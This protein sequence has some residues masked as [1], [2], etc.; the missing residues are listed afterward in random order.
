MKS[1]C[2]SRVFSKW[3]SRANENER[4]A[5]MKT[6]IGATTRSNRSEYVS[7]VKKE[8]RKGYSI[9]MI[10]YQTNGI[11]SK[12]LWPSRDQMVRIVPGYDPVTGQVFSQNIN[13]NEYCTD[14]NL[15]DYL[16]DTFILST[17]VNGFGASRQ[18]FITDFAPGSPDEEK[19]GG[20]TPIHWFIRNMFYS[21]N[22]K[23]K[24]KPKYQPINEWNIWC[25]KNGT[26]SFDKA[27]LMFQAL[28]YKINGKEMQDENEQPL[29][30]EQGN[31]LPLFGIVAIDN[32]AS[33][34]LLMQALVEPTNPALPLDAIN[35]NKY[36]G[37]AEMNGNMLFLNSV[38]DP[39]SGKSMMRPSVQLPGKGWTATPLPLSEDNVKA[40]WRPWEQILHYMTA[41]E[42]LKLLAAEFGADT[43]NYL[44]G[45]DPKFADL[46]MPDE[47]AKA[48]FGRYAQFCG[49][50][51]VPQKITLQQNTAPAA[52]GGLAVPG[53]AM[54]GAS[55]AI[56]AVPAAPAAAPAVP[57]APGLAAPRPAVP[58]PP[59]PVAKPAV[60]VPGMAVSNA[61]DPKK[62]AEEVRKMKAAGINTPVTPASR[63]LEDQAAAAA[64]LL[65]GDDEDLEQVV[66][67]FEEDP[68]ETEE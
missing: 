26:I 28:M 44:I 6:T 1:H 19:W 61:V 68:T 34:N 42:Q 48:G 29:V 15:Q 65:E 7:I 5:R 22:S 17:I 8:F 67:E 62:I 23:S 21:V 14:A 54:P 64:T 46:Q 58:V 12:S 31:A 55:A 63:E 18:T 37:L 49:G 16:S 51:S 35:N 47:I 56:P 30:D 66:P 13:A 27:A 60:T 53:I 25:G 40:L 9:P 20:D 3:P 10:P 33:I 43:V 24:R 4:Y 45:T 11:I 36:G 57:K 50:V 59:S 32:V 52:N 38:K 2:S 39:E 41:E